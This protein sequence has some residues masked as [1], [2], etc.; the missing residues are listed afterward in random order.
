M[1]DIQN[2]TAKGCSLTRCLHRSAVALWLFAWALAAP[3]E[4]VT[5]GTLGTAQ[6]LD[7]PDFMVSED[8]GLR[9]GNN[10]FHSFQRFNLHPGESATFSG[11]A[12]I[13]HLISRVTGGTASNLDGLLRS[14][15]GQADLYLINPAGVLFGP[16][17]SLDIPASFYV[18]AADTLT[19]SDGAQFSASDPAASTLGI[20]TPAAFGFLGTAGGRVG[21]EGSV[22]AL[23]QN[24]TLM[25]AGRG[26]DI[27]NASLSIE[28]GQ[29]VLAAVG[30]S[31][32]ETPFASDLSTQ[33]NGPIRL[34]DSEIRVIGDGGGFITL[35]GGAINIQRSLLDNRNSGGLERG[36]LVRVHGD[37]ISLDGSGGLQAGVHAAG[38]GPQIEVEAVGRL[39]IVNGALINSSTLGSGDAGEVF[40]TAGSLLIDR[41]EA[42]YLTGVVSQ[43]WVDNTGNA[44]GLTLD[45]AGDLELLGGSRVR[46]VSY[47]QGDAGNVK[48]RAGNLLIDGVWGTSGGG[49]FS[50]SAAGSA[51]DGGQVNV[52]VAGRTLILDGGRISGS[53]YS[54]GGQA[55]GVTLRTG[56][57]WI[58]GEGRTTEGVIDGATGG[59]G[60]LSNTTLRNPGDEGPLVR[61]EVADHLEILNRGVISADSYYSD[62]NAGRVEVTAGSIRIDG[63]D[64]DAGFGAT[65]ISSSSLGGLGTGGDIAVTAD[66]IEIIDG[67]SIA[68]RATL[69]GDSGSIDVVADQLRIEGELDDAV[70]FQFTGIS[71]TAEFSDGDAGEITLDVAGEI[72]LLSG[73]AISSTAKSNVGDAG[74]ITITAGSIRV[75]GG[76]PWVDSA[77]SSAS[78]SLSEGQVG[79]IAIR[80]GELNLEDL[81]AISIAAFGYLPADA[82]DAVAHEIQIDA[83]RIRL[84]RSIITAQS[85]HNAPAADIRIRTTH[86]LFLSD[87]SFIATQANL[88][89][90]GQIQI[91]GAPLLIDNGIVT[92]SVLGEQGNGGDI[93]VHVET[94]VMDGGFI[95]ANTAA[96][97]GAGGDIQIETNA[98]ITARQQPLIVGGQERQTVEL[99]RQASIIQA[100]APNGV[101]GQIEV[102]SPK[103]DL[104]SSLPQVA[105][106]FGAPPRIG[107][108]HCRVQPGARPS[109]LEWH[110]LTG[111]LF[112][113][114]LS[115]CEQDGTLAR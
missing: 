84:D 111:G 36:A 50:E 46:S 26:L 90:G 97:S 92:T 102:I 96:Q 87:A 101:S 82:G 109:S 45:I 112:E 77:I 21:V 114:Q 72:E 80:T 32:Q 35:S 33:P 6:S 42:E 65:G 24:R 13:E 66:T 60:I 34:A 10:L 64:D 71:T 22:M 73:G 1:F 16:N 67:G 76:H 12:D 104:A 81:G 110:G 15:V 7:G 91:S 52:D 40:I 59:T 69:S 11:A 98:M 20:A 31:A 56:S 55:G 27:R 93:G 85:E 86:G 19:F 47:A 58:D 23:P 83:D 37:D 51:G 78:D 57:L 74:N 100:A 70:T 17:V 4:I 49:L 3:A 106:D 5:D 88:A 43:T 89:D 107:D 38:K 103:T 30:D 94:L 29:V 48:V 62:G 18:G 28:A 8:L 9:A 108:H 99:G 113:Q 79:D 44:A 63:V 39:S 95:Q 61:V 54:S 53:S 115:G 75:I 41:Q 2:N 68:A 14:E 25:L 105:A